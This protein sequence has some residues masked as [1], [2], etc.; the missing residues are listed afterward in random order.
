MGLFVPSNRTSHRRFAY[1]PRFY[2]PKKDDRIK[3]RIRIQGR[4]RRRRSPIGIIYFLLLLMMAIYI[5][6]SLG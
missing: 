3:K 4:A 1:R 6:T 2:D 5:Y